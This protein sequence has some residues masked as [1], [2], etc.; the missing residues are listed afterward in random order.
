MKNAYEVLAGKLGYPQSE[1]FMK[2]LKRLMDEEEAEITASLPCS[3][4]ELAGKLNK[5]EEKI[6]EKLGELFKKGLIFMTSKGYQFARDMAQLHDATAS[7]VRSDEIWGSELL[8]LWKEFCEAELYHD[9]AKRAQTLGAPV[10]RIIPAKKGFPE[11][12]KLLPAEDLDIILDKATKFAV[13]HCPCR[14]IARRCDFPV[15]VCLQIN[16]A[17]EYAIARGTSRELTRKE[18]MEVLERSE[19]AG[20]VHTVL[21]QFEVTAI[22]CN[23]CNDCCIGLYPLIKHGDLGQ[24]IAKS[25]FLAEVDRIACTG[26]QVCVERCPFELIEMIKVLGQKKLKARIDPEKC[27]GCGVCAVECKAGAIKL[28]EM[29]PPEHIPF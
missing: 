25:R 13:V 16:R 5:T 22:I 15:E 19:E 21:N 8:D 6:N 9:V 29:R 24:G 27:L 26:C 7:D 1:K 4:F 3:S 10:F 17:A 12:T 18:A 11:G 20:L 14:R 2:V 28:A 23:C